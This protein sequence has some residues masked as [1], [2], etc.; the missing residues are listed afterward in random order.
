MTMSTPMK[1]SNLELIWNNDQS[2][3]KFPVSLLILKTRTSLQPITSA[4]KY[5]GDSGLKYIR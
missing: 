2:I 4:C 1:K 5:K 3:M